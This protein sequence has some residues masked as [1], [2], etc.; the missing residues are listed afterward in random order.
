MRTT[1]AILIAGLLVAGCGKDDLPALPEPPIDKAA[2]ERFALE[3]CTAC[4]GLDGSGRTAEIPNLAGQP[5]DY[6]EEAMQAYH[7]GAR[8]HAALQDLIEACT[9]ADIR[10]IAAYYASLPP[11]A[12]AAPEV[13]AEP[14]YAEGRE[15]AEACADCHGANGFS[16]TAGV[17]N[18][19]GQHPMYLIMATQEYASGR[20]DNTEKEAMLSGLDN[21]DV[22]KMAMFYAAQSPES[23]LAP[24]FGDPVAG[25]AQTAVCGSCH[26]A[27]GVSDDPMVPNLAAQEPNYLVQA[28]RAYRDRNRSHEDMMANK[29]DAEIEDIA[30]YY[31]VQTAGPVAAGGSRVAEI[32]AKCERCHGQSV[33]ESTMVVPNLRGQNAD[34]L[35]RVMKQYRD[36]ERGNTMMHKMSA[37]YSDPVLAEIAE[38]YATQAQAE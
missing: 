7:S 5:A 20:R 22:E 16:T 36:G 34:Y 12:A 19:A 14:V 4:H 2:G 37:G 13:R 35:L 33:G 21:V 25:E 18:L 27:R 1:I 17:P 15:V 38:Y 9:A 26:G 10:N 29:S 11:V 30:A 32:I 28:I 24:A 8:R 6:L 23:R 31:A 3:H